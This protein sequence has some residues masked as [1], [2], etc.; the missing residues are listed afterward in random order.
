VAGT[1][2]GLAVA[3]RAVERANGTITLNSEL[4]RGTAVTFYLRGMPNEG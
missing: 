4:G 2:L 1:G 3:K